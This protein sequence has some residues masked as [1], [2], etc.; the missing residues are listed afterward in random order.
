M[1]RG[2]IAWSKDELPETV[3]DARVAALQTAMVAQGLDALVAYTTPARAA[4]VAWIAGFV[5]YWNQGLVVIPR[6]GRPVLVSAL[7]NRVNGW[8]RRNAHV[9]DVK[10]APRIGAEAAQLIASFTPQAAV[11]I[12]D[13]PH[14][15]AAIVSDLSESGHRASDA[16]A[17]FRGVRAVSDAADI[18]LHERAADIAQHALMQMAANET[19][20]ARAV[21][22]IDGEA[23]RLGAEEVYPAVATDL[24]RSTHP[25]RLE[26]SAVMGQ[27]FAVRLSVAYKG[28]WVRIT[29]TFARD[30]EQSARIAAAERTFAEMA[31]AL[32]RLE[33]LSHAKTWLVEGTRTA[34]PLEPLAGSMIDVP[35]PLQ[36][37]SIVS[38]QAL[39]EMEGAPVLAGASVLLATEGTRLLAPR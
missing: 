25:V 21:A 6:E 4:A 22:R 26:G 2:L 27:L 36:T 8:M 15:P 38:V 30:V 3:L 34:L 12:V 9:A 23:R 32:A 5:P 29:R 19:D 16:S 24:M 39:I 13:L 10:N 1:R 33:A 20:A 14:L 11:G 31:S 18:A 7:S 35:E 37:G 28:A 17:L